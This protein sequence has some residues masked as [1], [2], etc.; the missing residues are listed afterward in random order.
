MARNAQADIAELRA[1]LAAVELEMQ[2]LRQDV[3]ELRD[4]LIGLRGGW[5]LLTILITISATLGAAA[6]KL[7]PALLWPRP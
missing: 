4:T 3:R 7:M 1:R 6:S 2:G 5:R